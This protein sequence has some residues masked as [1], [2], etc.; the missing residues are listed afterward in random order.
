MVRVYLDVVPSI[1]SS[2]RMV[3]LGLALRHLQT[4]G[5]GMDVDDQTKSNAR[6]L[7]AISH[8]YP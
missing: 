8:A 2:N 3:S 4:F 6:A 7:A 5:T 1:F